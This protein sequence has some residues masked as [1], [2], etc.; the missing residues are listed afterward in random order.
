MLLTYYHY[1]L[2]HIYYHH[3]KKIFCYYHYVVHHITIMIKRRCCYY[4]YVVHYRL[5]Y[6]TWRWCGGRGAWR[7]VVVKPDLSFKIS[8]IIYC[9]DFF[10][11]LFKRAGGRG[12]WGW[13]VVKPDFYYLSFSIYKDRTYHLS[14]LRCYIS[15]II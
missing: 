15:F 11:F 2:N 1:D 5:W 3:D 8:F 14:F 9:I 6:Q 13:V 12:T 7:W 10:I 4:H